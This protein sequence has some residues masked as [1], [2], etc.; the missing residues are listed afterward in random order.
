MILL[1]VGLAQADI[2]CC[3]PTEIEVEADGGQR[4]IRA[5]AFISPPEMLIHEGL[6]PPDR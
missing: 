5:V 6:P 1:R 4:S 3:R 2:V